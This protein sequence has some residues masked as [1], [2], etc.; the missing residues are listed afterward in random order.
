MNEPVLSIESLTVAL[1]A[2]ADRALA[3]DDVSLRV[4][5]GEVLCLVGE[6]GS[7]K[8]VCAL[9]AL[10][11][12]PAALTQRGGRVLLEGTDLATL[13]AAGMRA[14][15][16]RRV[17]MVFQEPLSALNPLMSVG[18]QIAEALHV[19]GLRSRDASETRVQELLDLVGL[20]DPR[21]LRRRLPFQ[22]SGG[23][24]QRVAIA[25]ALALEPALLVADEPTTA[26]D[27]TT[28]A[29][30]LALLRSLGRRL[31]MAVLFVTHDFGVVSTMADR[32]AVMQRGRIVEEGEA[33]AVLRAPVHPYT[34]ELIDAVRT[35]P[36]PSVSQAGSSDA[37]FVAV[38]GLSVRLGAPPGS[39]LRR[40]LGLSP[41]GVQALD[42]VSFELRAGQTLGIVGES[43][44]GKSTLA[45]SLLRLV[46][47][48]AGEVRIG[49]VDLSRLPERRLRPLR[50]Q[51]QMVF[52][53]PKAALNPRQT[54]GHAV[55]RALRAAGVSRVQA[56]ARA[57]EWLA[58]VGLDAGAF[59]RLPAEFSGGQR[60]RI[61]IARALALN[62]R[63]L[64]A[65]EPV[66]A[67]DVTV[68]GQILALLRDLQQRLALT[69]VFITHDLRV[70]AT[71]CHRIAVMHRGRLVEEGEAAQV[72]GA[73]MHPYTRELLA[74]V[75]STGS[76]SPSGT[77]GA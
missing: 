34:R 76:P 18:D 32:V 30:V 5:A 74:A 16:G 67:L 29:R 43:G 39:A 47:L 70:A 51:W 48:D 61:V 8:S 59:D 60:Q 77:G 50:H 31:G 22:L 62:P 72:L 69:M 42:G 75:P 52:Q 65:D 14:L 63:L 37:P 38:R 73:P 44:S 17:A 49:G 55:S 10:R 26:L 25:M 41:R 27:V 71:L 9:A 68:Q 40:R 7:G 19:H 3:V 4:H 12:L 45:R 6:S 23:Q 24:R 1:P 66:S 20:P 35:S 11:M 36:P 28:Q 15:R 56:D 57:R 58:A 53:D 46:R 54:A 2:G 13:D 21:A 64:V 33:S